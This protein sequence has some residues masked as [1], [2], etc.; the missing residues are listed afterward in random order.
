MLDFLQSML[1]R[2]GGREA[3]SY[4]FEWRNLLEK[5]EVVE[6]KRS[7]SKLKIVMRKKAALGLLSK[8]KING[9]RLEHE[10]VANDLTTISGGYVR[11]LS[12][13]SKLE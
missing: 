8:C 7:G 13:N 3:E 1:S 5:K 10:D 11:L 9:G 12:Y 2:S 4:E 6:E